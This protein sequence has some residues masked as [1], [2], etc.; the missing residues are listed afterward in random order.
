MDGLI[1][2]L[3]SALWLGILTS[4]S[5]CPLASN[6]AA[7]S[8][9]IKKMN[10]SSAVF[11]SGILYTAGRV[12]TYTGLGI[13]ISLSLLNV[14]LTSHF[15]QKYMPRF[16]GPVLIIT[17]LFL[18]EL[19]PFP[20]SGS[21]LSEKAVNR[22]KNSGILSSLLLGIFFAL[23]F[24]PVSAALFFGSLIPLSLNCSSPVM[25]P[26]IYGI[27]TGLPVLLFALTIAFG[28][29]NISALFHKVTVMEYWTRKVTGGIFILIGIYYVLTH[30]FY[31]RI[32]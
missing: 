24:C 9:I 17:G 8:F 20:V 11:M 25:L 15:L 12:I 7:V 26:L 31:V 30:I 14:P 21:H 1:L 13:L 6:V 27:G 19:I 18:L 22:F 3:V 28:V 32:L 29:Q 4:I 10:K 16:I 2:P 5:P 23:A